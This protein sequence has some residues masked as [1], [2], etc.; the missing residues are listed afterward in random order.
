VTISLL[1]AILAALVVGF[2]LGALAR[3]FL[4]NNPLTKRVA[5]QEISALMN[6]VVNA[7]EL[8]EARRVRRAQMMRAGRR[9][10]RADGGPPAKVHK[11]RRR[12]AQNRPHE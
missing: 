2:I 8:D 9:T 1:A 3:P 11:M 6:R 5:P 4:S 10:I 12:K 7:E